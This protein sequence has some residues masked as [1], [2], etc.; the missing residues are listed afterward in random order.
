MANI[1]DFTDLIFVYAQYLKYV[2]VAVATVSILY[3]FYSFRIAAM[4]KKFGGY[5]RARLLARQVRTG[6]AGPIRLAAKTI[7]TTLIALL[8]GLTLLGPKIKEP[9]YEKEYE[10]T[11]IVI[12]MDSTISMLAED[13]VPSRLG[14]AK[15]VIYRLLE[16]L[17]IEGS[18][19]KVGLI[20]FT[21]IAIPAVV[22]P[23]KDYRLIEYELRLTTSEYL[24]I[25]ESHGTNIWDAVTQGLNL[26][27]YEDSQ[28]KILIIISDGEQVSEP[29]YIDMT[30]KE[31]M[32]E[33]F[34]DVRSRAV[35]IFIIGI[36]DSNEATLI[37]K[38]KNTDGN[39]LEFYSQSNGPEKGRLITTRPDPAYLEEIASLIKGEFRPS[40]NSDK[41]N[42]DLD[43]ILNIERKVL[44]T[45]E[46][47]NLKDVSPWFICLVL[48]LMLFLPIIKLG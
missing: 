42:E 41:L 33:R 25:F 1:P 38:E 22:I 27:A 20:R 30:R 5:R 7:I 21:D 46:N 11:Q 17:R 13:V 19:D 2:W 32:D 47:V 37:P 26:F 9:K 8:L 15:E 48:V 39:T 6:I 28:E 4:H 14:A 10:P 34:G 31:A 23:T 3:V 18:K 36:G 16:R 40:E 44:G 35:K 43:N 45:N 24:K 29:E 12:A